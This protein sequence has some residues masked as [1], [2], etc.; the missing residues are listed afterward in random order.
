MKSSLVCPKCFSQET[1]KRGRGQLYCKECGRYSTVEESL[2]LTFPRQG[3][4]DKRYFEG[5]EA[6]KVLVFDIET[7][8][9]IGNFWGTGKQYISHDNILEDYVVLSWSAKWL[10]SDEIMG[11][12]LTPEEASRRFMGIFK[13]DLGPHKSDLRVLK[14]IW[15]LLDEAHVVIT[16][17]G[18]KFDVKKLNTRFLHYDMP[19]PHPF[20]HIDT[21]QAAYSSF[22]PSSAKLDY[23]TK[24]L[25]LPRK[26]P[27][28]YGL[29]KRCQ[30]G[31]PTS[32][33]RMNDY[34]L[35]D[36]WILEDYY[37]KI[38]AWIPKHPN[39]S[40][41]TNRYVDIEK[42]EHSCPVCRNPISKESLH[43]RPYRT[44]LGFQYASFRCG[45]CKAIGRMSQRISGQSIPVQRAG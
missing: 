32:L 2:A 45:N 24:F 19:P 35:N 36:T 33:K 29:W 6:P 31:D 7:L 27:T 17:N 14:S 25:S 42:G 28:D 10:F 22:S 44:P 21:L 39:F 41:Y 4:A 15:K 18:I 11:D 34:G 30:I 16:Q 26:R 8:P 37:S 5:A 43:G 20:H 3:R 23:M 13:P 9:L 38:R 1:Q 40:A 12:I